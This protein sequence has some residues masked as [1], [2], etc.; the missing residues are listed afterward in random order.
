[1]S[2]QDEQYDAG[3]VSQVKSKRQRAKFEREAEL[4]DL[5]E[6]LATKGGRKFLWRLLDG[7][8]LYAEMATQLDE[9]KRR[10][11]LFIRNEILAADP[12]AYLLMV[13]EHSPA[14]R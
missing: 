1:M 13:K 10:V 4:F 14:S 7:C 6:I 8:Q 3:D 11:G 12:D 9:G 5:R 2:S